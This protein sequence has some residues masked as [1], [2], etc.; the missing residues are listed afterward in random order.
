MFGLGK[1]EAPP[2][3]YITE[4]NRHPRLTHGRTF[5]VAQVPSNEMALTNCLITSPSDLGEGEY[6]ICDG[7]YV[8]TTKNHPG[9]SPGCVGAS[10]SAR[11]WAAWSLSQEVLVEPYNPFTQ[12]RGTYLGSMDLEIGFNSRSRTST[13]QYDQDALAKWLS[14]LYQNQMFAPGQRFVMEYKG[15]V[16]KLM[17]KAVQIVELG[18]KNLEDISVSQ[19]PTARGILTPHTQITFF[20][21]PDSAIKLKASAKRPAQSALLRTNFNL[22]ELGIGGL[23]EEFS[24]IFRRAFVS[25]TVSPA[26]TEKLGIQHVKGLLLYGP[27][28]TGKTLIARKIGELLNARPPKIVNGPEILNKYVGQS[29][30]NIR[31]LFADAEKEYKSKGAESELHLIIFDELDAILKQRGSK[32]DGT[33]VGD[34][35]VNQLLAKMDGVEQLNNIL[36]IGMTNRKDLI[37]EALLRPGRFAVQVPISL[38]D[39]KGRLQILQ[40]HTAEMRKNKILAKDISLETLASLTKNFTG[41]ELTEVVNNAA[42]F[43]LTRNQ[44]GTKL[45]INEDDVHVTMDDFMHALEEIK[46]QF[47]VTEDEFKTLLGLGIVSFSPTIDHILSTGQLLVDDVRNNGTAIESMLLY[48]PPGAGKTALAAAIAMNSQFPSMKVISP[49]SLAG[50]SEPQKVAHIQKVFSDSYNA[51]LNIILLDSIEDLIEWSAVGLR[52]SNMVLQMIKTSINA[53]PP[54]KRQLLVIA[55]TS[56]RKVLE[57]MSLSQRFTKE[58][59]VPNIPSLTEL[60]SLL[61]KSRSFEQAEAIRI[62]TAI[63]DVTN[64]DLVNVGVKA[65]LANVRLSKQSADSS[66]EFIDSMIEVIQRSNL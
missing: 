39:E 33:G 58:I 24:I 32:N 54:A 59:P 25:R 36:V 37:D 23:D 55:T 5:R 42:S 62:V 50:M 53:A 20:K 4:T 31:N 47:G 6:V 11:E 22:M 7:R 38:P 12:G 30:E 3:P 45:Q 61:I 27:P 17:V 52:Y 65:V 13:D 49:K 2:P 64:S 19:S 46:P 57:S 15:I 14:G 48:G 10:G 56:E 43:A 40:I 1:K 63:K 18:E 66:S 9:M 41:A 34:N 28:G 35:V 21:A 8:F 16:L 29:E 60:N 44:K 51:P 26:L